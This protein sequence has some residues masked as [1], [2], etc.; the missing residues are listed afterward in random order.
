MYLINFSENLA[1]LRREKKITQEQLADFVGVTKASVSKWETGQS[2]PDVMML[3]ELANFFDITIDELIGYEPQLS[4]EQMKK[5]YIDLC[6]EFATKPFEE[7]M[8]KSNNLV[9]RYYSCYPFLYRI[10]ILWVNHYMLTDDLDKQKNILRETLKLCDRIIDNSK[11]IALCNDVLHG[12]A[13]I[14]LLLGEASEVIDILEDIMNPC[15]IGNQS[16][17]V[18]IKAY[19]LV[20]DID[21]SNEYA[22]ITMYKKVLDLVNCAVEY[23]TLHSTNL[24][25][26]EETLRRIELVAEVYDLEHLNASGIVVFYYQM[27]VVY[28]MHNKI[29]KALLYLEKYVNITEAFLNSSNN[30]LHS[31][32]YF[33]KIDVWIQHLELGGNIPR[34]KNVIF[35]SALQGLS[36]PVFDVLKD[37]VA[38]QNLKSRLERNIKL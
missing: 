13:T 8:E 11:D 23:I 7:V 35:G 17:G 26:C 20:G 10:I 25:V 34:D 15:R 6:S 14:K 28:C 32:D 37:E 24:C 30:I 4:T 38:F 36:I 31:D 3:P 27:S 5:I 12:E 19:Q 18:L 33:D 21:K 29:D 2:I 22:Q 16:A 1:R 9:K